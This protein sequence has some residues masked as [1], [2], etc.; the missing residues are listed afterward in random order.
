MHSI[1]KSRGPLVYLYIIS[2]GLLK[3]CGYSRFLSWKLKLPSQFHHEASILTTLVCCNIVSP[4]KERN[5]IVILFTY[6]Q[7]WMIYSNRQVD[8]R[9]KNLTFMTTFWLRCFDDLFD[10]L[11]PF[12][13]YLA[14]VSLAKVPAFFSRGG[15]PKW[16]PESLWKNNFW[17]N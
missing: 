12:K 9:V 10:F 15:N 8:S 2:L 6:G 1:L 17:H 5:L 11:E 13:K 4:H 3:I 14:P 16:P 7:Y